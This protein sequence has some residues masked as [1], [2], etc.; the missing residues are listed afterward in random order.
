M[1]PDHQ[2]VGGR[3]AV[4]LAQH[5][6]ILADQAR[7][8]PAAQ[9]PGIEAV[10]HPQRPELGTRR[11]ELGPRV[12]I[13]RDD[14][15]DVPP[16]GF[17]RLFPGNKVR[18]KYGV[19]VECLG[20][21]KDAAGQVTAVR[22]K[23]VPDTK[24]GTPGADAVKVKGTITWVAA[25][26]AVPVELRL[27]DHLF[28]AEQPDPDEG[29]LREAVNPGSRRVVQGWLE[30]SLS[31]VPRETRFQFERH[32][33][34]IADRMDHSAGRPVYNRITGLKDGWTPGK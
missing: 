20:A 13:E 8:Q 3:H 27:Y 26:D 33:Y 10:P 34:F 22:A 21:E 2:A 11:F 18:L 1:V 9:R 6:D 31:D 19:V 29:G 7:L 17:F 32:G 4:G 14:Y 5:G 16:K 28:S 12:W 30:P 23:V 25:H 15:A 24:S